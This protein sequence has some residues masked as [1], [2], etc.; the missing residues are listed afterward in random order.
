MSNGRFVIKFVSQI[1]LQTDASKKGW[2]AVFQGLQTWVLWSKKEQKCRIFVIVIAI[3]INLAQLAFNKM[4]KVKS[5]H[6]HV[7]HFN[8]L[9]YLWKWGGTNRQQLLTLSKKIWEFHTTDHDY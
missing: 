8:A 2:G 6:I 5:V 1:L 3:A 4:M 7:D 9:S